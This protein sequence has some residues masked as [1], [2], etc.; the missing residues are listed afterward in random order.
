MPKSRY[1]ANQRLT[2]V[3]DYLKGFRTASE[4]RKDLGIAST[5]ALQIMISKSVRLKGFMPCIWFCRQKTQRKLWKL[6]L[7]SFVC[8]V[9]LLRPCRALCC[10]VF[11]PA[12]L[13]QL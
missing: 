5:S 11:N 3:E 8:R 7:L 2:A 6:R 1:S 13:F 10:T 4:I 12:F 9:L